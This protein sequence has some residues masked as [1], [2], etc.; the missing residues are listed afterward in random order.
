MLANVLRSAMIHSSQFHSILYLFAFSL[1]IL[2]MKTKW[3][4]P[5]KLFALI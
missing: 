4:L 2:C 1:S 3:K 5:M